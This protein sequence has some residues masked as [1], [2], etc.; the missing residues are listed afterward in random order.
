MARIVI[1]SDDGLMTDTERVIPSE[2]DSPHF[3]RC[4]VERVQWAV[5]DAHRT[6]RYVTAARSRPRERDPRPVS[7]AAVQAATRKLTSADASRR[8]AAKS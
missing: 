1:S 3:R 7:V 5:S 8:L 6:D 2:I 4:L